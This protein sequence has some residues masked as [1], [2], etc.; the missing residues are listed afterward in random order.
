MIY[1]SVCSGIEA[2]TVAWEPL[3]WK[4]RFFAEIDPFARAVLAHR[5]PGVPAHGD[6]RTITEDD[7]EPIALLAGG[8][9]CQDFSRAGKRAG[10]DGENGQLTFEFVRLCERLMPR[11]FV[12]ENVP[13]VLAADGGRAFAEF[14]AGLVECG[15]GCAWRVLDAQR[16][17]VPQRRRRVFVVGYRGDWRPPAAVLFEPACAGER[18]PAHADEVPDGRDGAGALPCWWNGE[19]VSQTV[20]TVFYKRQTMPEKNRLPALLDYGDP[21]PVVFSPGCDEDDN[22][23]ACGEDYAECSCLGPTQDG[24]DY[25][26]ING[27]LLGRRPRLRWATPRECER[28]QGFPDDWTLVPWRGGMASDSARYIALGN[29]MP[30]PVMRWIGRRIEMA[31][32]AIRK[33]NK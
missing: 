5:L 14:I 22:C 15:F 24:V 20:D 9:P 18:G 2:T 17:G 6:F 32:E 16:F 8:T 10:M 23:T 25:I 12:W 30:V 31:D 3:G 21:E 26:E 4:P 33:A 19:R 27:E 11:W 7:Y 29:S 13:G 28:L 1:G